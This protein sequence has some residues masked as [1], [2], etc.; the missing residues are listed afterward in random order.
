MSLSV[1]NKSPRATPP[2]GSGPSK[3]PG[4]CTRASAKIQAIQPEKQDKSDADDEHEKGSASDGDD[5]ELLRRKIQDMQTRIDKLEA[6][7]KTKPRLHK[8]SSL[9][10]K[11]DSENY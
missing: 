2:S 10:E 8:P 9:D 6:P 7:K 4:R 3:T 11:Y 1:S 5:V